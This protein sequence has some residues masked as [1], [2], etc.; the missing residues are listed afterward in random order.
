MA[1]IEAVCVVHELRPDDPWAGNLTAIDKR[2]VT[3]RSMVHRLGVE[4][5][6]QMDT[7]DHGGPDK[8]VY[9]Y[10][11]ED[12]SWWAGQLDRELEPGAFGENLR[13]T[14]LDVT[15][16]V[17]GEQ[18]HVGDPDDGVVLEVTMP[19]IPCS[20]FQR[21]MDEPHWVKRFTD[22]GAPGA[23]LRV[24]REGTVAAGDRIA[25]ERRPAHGVTIGDCFLRFDAEIGQRLV[26]AAAAGDLDLAPVLR[27][28]AERSLTR[29]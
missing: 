23:Y 12:V 10:A 27:G 3:G 20:T 17:I 28:F 14:G 2:A 15:G 24:V 25:V 19:R 6:R 29:A 9:A 5:D 13:T 16:A 8:A 7:Q 18:W 11:G 21:W 22:H 26:D 4:G 1:L